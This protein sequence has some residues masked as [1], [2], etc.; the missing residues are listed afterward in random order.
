M[1]DI[2][3][4][5]IAAALVVAGIG[6][7][8]G[9]LLSLSSK[10]MAVKT[11]DRVEKIRGCLPGANCGACGFAGCD[12]YAVALIEADGTKT[13]LCI[14]GGESVSESISEILGVESE[15]VSKVVAFVECNGNCAATSKKADYQGIK[16]CAAASLLYGGDGKCTY[17]CLGYGD[18]AEICPTDSI[19]IENGI[20][21]IDTRTCI[22]CGMCVDRC[23]K[24]IISLRTLNNPVYVACSNKDKGAIAR[25]QCKNACIGCKK[26]ESTCPTDAI[27][28]ENNLSRIDFSKCI[29]C[30]KC[31]EVCPTGCIALCE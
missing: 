9:I 6:L 1:P 28:V 7:L 10:F 31:V 3:I 17:G 4:A 12:G 21:H 16:T 11:D 30:K 13:N 2:V 26:C 25:K 24:H 20:S 23:P 15:S 29:V 5:L 19:C 27:K 18:C 14:P 8:C 22:G